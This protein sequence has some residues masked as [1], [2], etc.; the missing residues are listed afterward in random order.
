MN[1]RHA[2][3]AGNFADILKHLAL[4]RLLIALQRKETPLRVID[5]HAGAGLYDLSGPEALRSGEWRDGVARFDEGPLDGAAETLA[6]PFRALLSAVRRD[7]G[8]SAYPGSPEIARR[9][10]RPQDRMSLVEAHGDTATLLDAAIGRDRRATLLAQDG[11]VALNALIPP[12]E[13]RGLAL[14]DPAFEQADEFAALARALIA[15]WRKWPTGLYAVWHPVKDAAIVEA[16]MRAV[17]AG[18][19]AKVLRIELQVAPAD[20]RGLGGCGLVVVNPPYR[21]DEE[22]TLLLPAL[23]Q[24]L[25]RG[26]ARWRCDWLARERSAT[27][28]ASPAPPAGRSRRP[29]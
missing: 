16:F 26:A 14:I 3:H 1:Y 25:A 21:F 22:M 19:V 27:S 10:A 9:L 28:S 11:Y 29:R 12:P 15:A 18:G 5:T 24:R 2:F 23:A 8:S 4:T 20:M 13:R 17:V 7:H 6:A